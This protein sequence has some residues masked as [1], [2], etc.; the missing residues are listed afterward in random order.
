[1]SASGWTR[2]LGLRGAGGGGRA[3]LADHGAAL[4]GGQVEEGALYLQILGRLE[5]L[6]A[7]GA[8][9]VL[10]NHR[11]EEGDDLVAAGGSPVRR[12]HR[13]AACRRCRG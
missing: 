4:A 12:A 3:Q 13:S 9:H 2:A 6:V 5:A 1:M 10:V 7:R 8:G 11:I